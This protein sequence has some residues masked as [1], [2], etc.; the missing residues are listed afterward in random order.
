[1]NSVGG[2]T[3]RLECY[4]PQ[5]KKEHLRWSEELAQNMKC[6]VKIIDGNASKERALTWTRG[7]DI[8][9]ML[10]GPEDKSFLST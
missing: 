10:W 6:E 7:R 2:R 9:L 5:S 4:T 1:M 3:K 8:P